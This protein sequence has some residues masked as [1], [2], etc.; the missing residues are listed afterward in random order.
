MMFFSTTH[1]YKIRD[2]HMEIPVKPEEQWLKILLCHYA[3]KV[4]MG[5]KLGSITITPAKLII[6]Y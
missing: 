5:M 1:G 2:G 6:A 4:I 3:Q